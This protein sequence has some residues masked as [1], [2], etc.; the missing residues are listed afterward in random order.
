MCVHTFRCF[1]DP[2]KYIVD[3]IEADD[4]VNKDWE[5]NATLL[6]FPGGA[7]RFYR[8]CFISCSYIQRKLSSALGNGGNKRIRAFIENGG[9]Y[10]GLC[11]GG[12]YGT[13]KV[14]FDLH[15]PL[16]VNEERELKLFK[17]RAIGP[18]LKGFTYNTDAGQYAV[19]FVFNEMTPVE[20]K[21]VSELQEGEIQRK[22]IS[23]YKGGPYFVSIEASFDD[24]VPDPDTKVGKDYK[25]VIFYAKHPKLSCPPGSLAGVCSNI[26]KGKAVLLA[27]HVEWIWDTL[28]MYRFDP[29]LM[30]T[31]TNVDD[32]TTQL[33]DPVL[34]QGLDTCVMC[35]QGR[36]R[37]IYNILKTLNIDMLPMKFMEPEDQYF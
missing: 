24:Q 15:G 20:S 9:N 35:S 25:P 5:D 11:A 26:R 31:T 4:I 1:S 2:A 22:G 17:G 21:E 29:W 32:I 33:R 18:A 6:I 16:E 3:T 7:D 27:A 14:E 23:Y 30:K 34:K 12:Y 8:V 19:P 37:L 13:S 28:V 36:C 10:I